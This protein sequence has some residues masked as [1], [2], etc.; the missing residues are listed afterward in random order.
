[1]QTTDSLEVRHVSRVVRVAN[2]LSR[3]FV[4]ALAFLLGMYAL[5][6]FNDRVAARGY[7]FNTAYEQILKAE[8]LPGVVKPDGVFRAVYAGPSEARKREIIAALN[9]EIS[10]NYSTM[11]DAGVL[12]LDL[13]SAEL[14]F[15]SDVLKGAG[16]WVYTDHRGFVVVRPRQEAQDAAAEKV[17][18]TR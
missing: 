15:A 7:V 11:S 2:I 17:L 10:C 6:L 5:R 12:K 16:W 14:S 1:M 13:S 18:S 9:D 8:R 4:L 3:G